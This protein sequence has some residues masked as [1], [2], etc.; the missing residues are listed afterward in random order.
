MNNSINSTKDATAAIL[1][2]N[3]FNENEYMA[4]RRNLDMN[5]I[6]SIIVSPGK[7]KIIATNYF[8]RV[9]NHEQ[10]N[11]IS[12]D[13]DIH[14]W[15]TDAQI[16]DILVLPGGAFSIYQ[17]AGSKASINFINSFLHL[18][19][20]VAA[21]SDAI[22]LLSKSP[23]LNGK[24]VTS[25]KQHKNVLKATNALWTDSDVISDEGVITCRSMNSIFKF[26]EKI[27]DSIKQYQ[28]ITQ[29]YSKILEK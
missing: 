17:L 7:P 14:P 10:F 22:I 27:I 18:D 3:G 25:P 12:L 28:S 16:Y 9:N 19:I 26:N 20:P 29:V 24:I 11:G 8:T 1:A 2:T 5:G 23:D 6:K 15:S 21:I 4:I 13:V